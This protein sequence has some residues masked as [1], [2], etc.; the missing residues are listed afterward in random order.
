MNSRR[1]AMAAS[2]KPLAIALP[3]VVTSGVTPQIAW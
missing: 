1:P 3:S 2:G